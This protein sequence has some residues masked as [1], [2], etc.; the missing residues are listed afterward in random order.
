MRVPDFEVDDDELY[1]GISVLDADHRILC[2]CLGELLRATSTCADAGRLDEIAQRLIDC[3]KDHF[4][5]E[6]EWMEAINYEKGDAHQQEHQR[7]LGDLTI[8]LNHIRANG[9]YAL[10]DEVLG[11]L[12]GWLIDHIKGADKEFADHLA[13]LNESGRTAQ[14]EIT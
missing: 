9:E 7:L 5:R 3:A 1:L 13:M 8:I 4:C 6:Q 11:F 2:E 12:Q 10:G 14:G